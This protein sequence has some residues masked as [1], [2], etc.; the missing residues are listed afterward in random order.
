MSRIQE[1]GASPLMVIRI[2]FGNEVFKFNLFEEC[3]V[4]EADLETEL[5]DLPSSYSY[6]IMLHRKLISNLKV[7]EDEKKKVEARRYIHYATSTES[8]YYSTHGRLPPVRLAEAFTENDKHYKDI[9]S[10][11]LQ[12]SED[13]ATIEAAVRSFEVKKDLVQTLSANLRKERI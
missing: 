12:A 4:D 7:L 11:V 6:L 8:I 9:C 2:K 10:R 13:T 1:L 3:K 5:K